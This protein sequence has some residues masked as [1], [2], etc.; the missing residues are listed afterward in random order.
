MGFFVGIKKVVGQ[1][2]RD[3]QTPFWPSFGNPFY[4]VYLHSKN[5]C[6]KRKPMVTNNLKAIQTRCMQVDD[7][8]QLVS[9]I[10]DTGMRLSETTGLMKSDTNLGGD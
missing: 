10:S 9:L 1:I 6:K 5:P 2:P 7:V 4:G 8:Q 3:A